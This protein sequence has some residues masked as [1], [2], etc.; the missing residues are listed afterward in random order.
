[1]EPSDGVVVRIGWGYFFFSFFLFFIF[2]FRLVVTLS[3]FSCFHFLVGIRTRLGIAFDLIFSRLRS[4]LFYS[5]FSIK[6]EHD[7]FFLPFNLMMTLVWQQS[8]SATL[9]MEWKLAVGYMVSKFQQPDA[10]ANS[11]IFSI[12]IR[13]KTFFRRR[14]WR[15]NIFI[16]LLRGWMDSSCLYTHSIYKYLD[17]NTFFFKEVLSSALFACVLSPSQHKMG[18]KFNSIEFDL[19][20]CLSLPVLARVSRLCRT[21]R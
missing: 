7:L 12:F 3:P 10:D 18:I 8:Q 19:K 15:P 9:V 5:S 17:G 21:R 20:K 2:V 14:R 13:R 1:M 4:L 6:F 11:P 16:F